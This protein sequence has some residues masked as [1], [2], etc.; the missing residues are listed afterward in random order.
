MGSVIA[1]GTALASASPPPLTAE[2]GNTYNVYAADQESYDSNLYRLA[3]NFG[4]VA[5]LVSPNASR[6][7]R[8]NTSTVGADGQFSIGRQ[9]FDVNAHV[10][11][12]RFAR[13]DAL[14]NLS[15]YGNFLWNWLLGSYFSGQVGVDYSH[16]LAS[17]DE[18][19]YL[20]RDL[21]DTVQYN[22]S[23]RY[24]LGPKWAVYAGVSETDIV[25]SAK[26][27]AFDDFHTKA[28]VTGVQYVT[29]VNDTLGFEYRYTDGGFPPGD[30]YS[31]N[32]VFFSPNYHE[33][34]LRLLVNHSVS[35]KTQI[36]ANIGYLKRA[37]P[38]TSVGEFSGETW[39][40]TVNWQPTEKTQVSVAGYHE[41]HAYLVSESD[42]FV[43]K[44]ASVSPV[45]FA[46]DKLK[47]ALVVSLENQNYIENQNY[48]AQSNQVLATGPLT[49][50]VV[51]EQA[52]IS[53][54]PRDN[55]IVNLI[56]NHQSRNSNQ[57]SFAYNDDL[58]T[59]S[60]LYKFH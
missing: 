4:T 53:Y 58:A 45:W 10:D 34:L 39:R 48:V 40:V 57:A 31:L 3:T 33:N 24:Q 13:N 22:G 32:G 51:T 41:L 44:G 52:N 50:K 11:E 59:L 60:V 8:I 46:T 25:H 21:V 26:Q 5:T 36:G 47:V 12:N 9:T 37:Y 56:Y 17:F 55:W 6:A 54:N 2:D 1:S 35:D 14:N 7:D 38:N 23:G 29:G 20:G 28:G 42:Y 15:G 30:I 19:R 27:A 18:T 43:A 16:A 49:A